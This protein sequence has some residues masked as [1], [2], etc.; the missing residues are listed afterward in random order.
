M[1]HR[2]TSLSKILPT[3]HDI[4]ICL[5][6]FS[7][8]TDGFTQQLR[9]PITTQQ[10]D[11]Q[12]H[13]ELVQW[14]V[15]S[16]HTHTA[17]VERYHVNI[18]PRSHMA[19]CFCQQA[20]LYR[21]GYNRF[22]PYWA[23]PTRGGRERETSLLSSGIGW[24]MDAAGQIVRSLEMCFLLPASITTSPRET[25]QTEAVNSVRP[26]LP[27]APGRG[28]YVIYR[29]LLQFKD[30]RSDEKYCED[31]FCEGFFKIHGSNCTK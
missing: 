7:P 25:K 3:V 22:T 16:K 23:A 6:W 15:E 27:I 2:G 24:S 31:E 13:M 1:L 12:Q 29:Q 28:C 10:S 8:D 21:G 5:W 30:D 14:W 11:Q 26:I 4:Y 9:T 19:H 18:R 17:S 20:S